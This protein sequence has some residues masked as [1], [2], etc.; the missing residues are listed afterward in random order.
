MVRLGLV[1][2]RR[3][4]RLCPEGPSPMNA[5]ADT[6]YA[7]LTDRFARIATLNEAS[8]MLG[9]DAAAMMPPGGGAARGEQLAVLAGLAHQQLTS[10]AV[11]DDLAEA[12]APAEP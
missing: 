11:R 8:S 10:A 12:E 1:V 5:S 7:R 2:G 4:C 3:L 6:A 9:W